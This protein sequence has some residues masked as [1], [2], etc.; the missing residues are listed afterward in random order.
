MSKSKPGSAIFI[1]DAPEIIEKKITGAFCPPGEIEFNPII[2]WVKYLVFWGESEGHFEVKRK[3]E[4]GGDKVYENFNNLTEDYLK[5][6]F[7]PL[8]LK[9]AVASWLIKKLEPA[10]EHFANPKLKAQKEEMEKL[11]LL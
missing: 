5:N 10:R 1:H 2:N 4:F 11:T 7:H 3:K 9:N 6:N 8:D